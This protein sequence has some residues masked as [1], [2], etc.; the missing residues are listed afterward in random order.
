M[1]DKDPKPPSGKRPSDGS[2]KRNSRPPRPNNDYKPVRSKNSQTSRTVRQTRSDPAA[3]FPPINPSTGRVETMKRRPEDLSNETSGAVGQSAERL[4]VLSAQRSEVQKKLATVKAKKRT[5][6]QHKLANE[7]AISR[8]NDDPLAAAAS[9]LLSTP[10]DELGRVTETI[11]DLSGDAK[12]ITESESALQKML[13]QESDNGNVPDSL[14]AHMEETS[15]AK[16]RLIERTNDNIKVLTAQLVKARAFG[17]KA[18]AEREHERAVRIHHLQAMEEALQESNEEYEVKIARVRQEYEE[19]VYKMEAEIKM[20]QKRPQV[21]PLNKTTDL[22]RTVEPHA[23]HE[24]RMDHHDDAGEF[25]LGADGSDPL[26]NKQHNQKDLAITNR[27]LRMDLEHA[28]RDVQ[29]LARKLREAS[30]AFKESQEELSTHLS[31]ESARM[32]H[33][34]EHGV[35]DHSLY[36][37][38]LGQLRGQLKQ[39]LVEREQREEEICEL[40]AS[41]QATDRAHERD[42]NDLRTKLDM[43][44]QELKKTMREQNRFVQVDKAAVEMTQLKEEL[45]RVKKESAQTDQ[46]GSDAAIQAKLIRN[47]QE[48][49]NQSL[50]SQETM[51]GEIRRIER[52]HLQEKATMKAKINILQAM[53]GMEGE[54]E[55]ATTVD[56]AMAPGGSAQSKLIS[57]LETRL[58]T[59]RQERDHAQTELDKVKQELGEYRGTSSDLKKMKQQAK[60]H[61]LA[62]GQEKGI[63]AA[64]VKELRAKCKQMEHELGAVKGKSQQQGESEPAETIL[65]RLEIEGYDAER[66]KNVNEAQLVR[67]ERVT[68][69]IKE[70]DEALQKVRTDRA[71]ALN[72]VLTA[73]KQEQAAHKELMLM[74]KDDKL[75][76]AVTAR[77]TAITGVFA[78]GDVPTTTNTTTQNKMLGATAVGAASDDS[79]AQQTADDA[80]VA[81]AGEQSQTV[82]PAGYP[83][84]ASQAGSE[85]SSGHFGNPTQTNATDLTILE[86]LQEQRFATTQ[87]HKE[88]KYANLAAEAAKSEAKILRVSLGVQSECTRLLQSQIDALCAD[89]DDALARVS[90]WSEQRRAEQQSKLLTKAEEIQRQI[91]EV[92][93]KKEAMAA[94][95][96]YHLRLQKMEKLCAQKDQEMGELQNKHS[97]MKSLMK[98]RLDKMHKERDEDQVKVR[99]SEEAWEQK[100]STLREMMETAKMQQRE[101]QMQ[102][103]T[104]RMMEKGQQVAAGLSDTQVKKKTDVQQ[105]KFEKL[106]E[107]GL[108]IGGEEEFMQGEEDSYSRPLSGGASTGFAAGGT[109]GMSASGTRLAS[110]TARHKQLSTNDGKK[111]AGG[112]VPASS[113]MLAHGKRAEG[114]GGTHTQPS[115]HE[116]VRSNAIYNQLVAEVTGGHLQT[117]DWPDPGRMLA[118]R[119][120]ILNHRDVVLSVFAQTDRPGDMSVRVLMYDLETDLELVLQ[121]GEEEF[122]ELANDSDWWCTDNF[123]DRD[124]KR[125]IP[126][127][128]DKASE[129]LLKCLTIEPKGGGEL[130]LIAKAL[131]DVPDENELWRGNRNISGVS[132]EVI[133]RKADQMRRVEMERLR[134]IDAAQGELFAEK[135]RVNKPLIVVLCN[136]LEDGGKLKTLE[137]KPEEEGLF[138]AKQLRLWLSRADLTS[139]MAREVALQPDA[140]DLLSGGAHGLLQL[141]VQRLEIARN[142]R[143]GVHTL[144]IHNRTIER[145]GFRSGCQ[146]S[147]IYY[148]IKMSPGAAGRLHL[149]ATRPSKPTEVPLMLT[150]TQK[151]LDDIAGGRAAALMN[152]ESASEVLQPYLHVV[153]N[154]AGLPVMLLKSV[155]EVVEENRKTRFETK[156]TTLAQKVG[157]EFQQML[158]QS[159]MKEKEKLQLETKKEIETQTAVQQRQWARPDVARPA[160]DYHLS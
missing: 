18:A 155:E 90:T 34:S 65:V 84:P 76:A 123:F 93:K 55:A 135:Q 98:A 62:W 82:A 35:R 60:F 154:E 146:L 22:N 15:K 126:S 10:N 64:E 54:D 71:A 92:A 47:L 67:D 39:S 136:R 122:T 66:R 112:Y 121:L 152:V 83:L 80:S 78:R 42:R 51:K 1:T 33:Y 72:S 32:Q 25:Q 108:L 160:A 70:R 26:L 21:A 89:R 52:N 73:L 157:S 139:A 56:G 149:D 29:G 99:K 119:G 75:P 111:T 97:A 2:R 150:V 57:A 61:E 140:V 19:K 7:K 91:E 109:M 45:N 63:L 113:G 116:A 68:K 77:K 81:Q 105:A 40:R 94:S 120:M 124:R 148:L 102:M 134:R 107:D 69:A 11:P 101:H 132:C 30:L 133:V 151:E 145:R 129:F 142:E 44:R 12:K 96:E 104:R 114:I 50:T 6:T 117:N 118:R 4:D 156:K 17:K 138:D 128:R 43:T 31:G 106:K 115:C 46:S 158:W 13:A 95:S 88:A 8:I 159:N 127:A 16:D 27:S 9:D 125:L 141:V 14:R 20:L 5:M 41:M 153:K 143:S 147:G 144:R 137:E 49:L 131:K 100:I 86:E 23:I 110:P 59:C 130:Q 37:R 3:M 53:A 74:H 36:E 103:E 24:D 85:P 48:A 28:R 79:G 87:A 58:N 38:Q